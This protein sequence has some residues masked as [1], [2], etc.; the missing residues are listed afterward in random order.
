MK[1][2]MLLAGAAAVFSTSALAVTPY[3]AAKTTFQAD[4]FT[5]AGSG[6]C[7]TPG[8]PSHSSILYPGP[9]KTGLTLVIPSSTSA[10]PATTTDCVQGHIASGKLVKE[11]T[12]LTGGLDGQTLNFV[13]YSDTATTLQPNGAGLPIS[14]QFTVKPTASPTGLAWTTKAI[15]SI[16][17]LGCS[18]TGETTW[19]AE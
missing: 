1:Y 19:A 15:T 11:L 10:G 18:S 5:T 3:P 9:G 14:V 7:G 12:P 17:A 2:S 13:C 8:T 16:P 6:L 4:G